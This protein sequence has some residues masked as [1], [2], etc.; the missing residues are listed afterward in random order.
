MIRRKQRRG[1]ITVL[2]AVLLTALLTVAGLCINLTQLA[3]AKTEMRLACDAAA[4][5]GVVVLGQTQDED[6]ARA[7]AL[8]IASR[9]TVSGQQMLIDDF[10]VE[11]GHSSVDQA[12]G[13]LFAANELPLNAVRVN[14]RM[15]DDA[16]TASGTYFVTSFFDR[17]NFSLEYAAIASRVDHDICLVI[18]RS[19]SMAWDM[20]NEEWS[21]PNDENDGDDTDSIIQN[22]FVTPHPTLSRWAALR[23]SVDQFLVE[24]EDRPIDVSVGLVSYSSNFIFGLFESEASTIESDLTTQYD[25]ITERLETLGNSELIGNTNVA[26]GMQDA[27]TV[28]S[29]DESRITAKATMVVLTDGLWNQGTD[30]V[31]VAE[32]AAEA[33]ITVHTITFGAQADQASMAAVALAGGG[34]HYHADD[35]ATLQAVFAEIAQTLPAV[36]TQ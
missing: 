18:D 15:S 27:V 20:S 34:N 36:L 24:L 31:D 11:F 21:Y 5:A 7:A 25:T 33:N 6:E 19:G 14:T 30:P 22:Y 9:H 8:Q 12:G 23:T 17:E 16:M 32:A 1:N 3:T 29:G 4:K 10:D 35:G 26:S 2:S 28:L 13:Y